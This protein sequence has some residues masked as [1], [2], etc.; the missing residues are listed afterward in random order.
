MIEGMMDAELEALDETLDLESALNSHVEIVSQAAGRQRQITAK[1]QIACS[2]EQLWQI[3]TSY[4]QLA[5][6]I[7]SLTQSRQIEHPAGGIRIEQIGSEA[8]M[9]IKFCAR[10]VLDMV[11]QFP[12]QIDFE[13]VEGDFKQ[14][15]GSWM[16]QPAPNG[17]TELSYSVS[18]LP[19]RAMPVGLIER[20]LKSGLVA[21]L[22]AIRQRAET[23]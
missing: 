6:F 14:F 1:I 21:N 9:R 12:N 13:M 7:P 20:K 3:L 4:D 10:V 5:E 16:L 23:L 19:P 18:V 8:L 22:T 15:C 17:G 11:E 2:V